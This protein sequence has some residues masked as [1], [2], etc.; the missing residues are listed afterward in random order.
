MDKNI[1]LRLSEF[2]KYEKITIK[3]MASKIKI[4]STQLDNYISG[5]SLPGYNSLFYLKLEF[6]KLNLNWLINGHG[7][8]I[9]KNSPSIVGEPDVV[10]KT[11]LDHLQDKIVLLEKVVRDKE[12]K[13]MMYKIQLIQLRLNNLDKG[14]ADYEKTKSELDDWVRRLYNLLY[15]NDED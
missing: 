14:S 6:P 3:S 4:S 9:D 2:R 11:K 1:S 13:C 10:Y 8:M 15:I 7:E 5:K 12:E